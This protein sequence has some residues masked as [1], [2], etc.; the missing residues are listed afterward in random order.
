MVKSYRLMLRKKAKKKR[1]KSREGFII[2]ATGAIIGT[3]FVAQTA[4]VLNRF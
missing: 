1:K 3:A 2:G 4:N